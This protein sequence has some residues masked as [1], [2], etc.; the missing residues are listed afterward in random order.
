MH[1][2]GFAVKVLGE[3]GLPSHDARRWRSGPHLSVS[4]ERLDAILDRLDELDVR[5]Y[6]MTSDLAPYATHPDLPQFHR[7]VEECAEQLATIGAKVLDVIAPEIAE[8]ALARRL[9]AEE[10]AAEK[11][12]R[13]T[14]RDRGDGTTDIRIRVPEAGA[15]SAIGRAVSPTTTSSSTPRRWAS[16]PTSACSASDSSPSSSIEPRTAQVRR[17]SPMAWSAA[18]A[19]RIESGLAL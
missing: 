11:K 14:M 7:Q 19:A 12:T 2:L 15:M 4:L 8:E 16:A 17:P 10:R 9:E 13:L 3:G 1:R 6:R 5:M 18:R